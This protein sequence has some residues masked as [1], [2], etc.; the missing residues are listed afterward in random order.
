MSDEDLITVSEGS[1]GE[2]YYNMDLRDLEYNIP[3]KVTLLYDEPMDGEFKS[4]QSK[5]MV[6]WYNFGFAI[7]GKRIGTF[8]YDY[9][10][11]LSKSKS[12]VNA[13]MG[14]EEGDTLEITKKEGKVKKGKF[15]GKSFRMWKVEK[16]GEDTDMD[17]DALT[18]PDDDGVKGPTEKRDFK[19]ASGLKKKASGPTKKTS[20]DTKELTDKQIGTMLDKADFESTPANIKDVKDNVDTATKENVTAYLSG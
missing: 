4:K 19:K 13:L 17:Y 8:V 1:D 20:G 2:L 3:Q 6:H 5:K 15:A 9:Y 12:L 11:G 14:Y 16:V 7:D 10:K 18:G